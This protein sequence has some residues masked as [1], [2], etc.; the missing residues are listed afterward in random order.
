MKKYF[1]IFHLKFKKLYF[2]EK[3][4]INIYNKSSSRIFPSMFFS[5]ANHVFL[6]LLEIIFKNT[7]VSMW[8]CEPDTS[9]F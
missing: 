4:K 9:Y 5:W 2:I 6:I 7:D 1:C 8:K 3:I